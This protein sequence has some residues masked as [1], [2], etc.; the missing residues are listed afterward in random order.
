MRILLSCSNTSSPSFIFYKDSLKKLKNESKNIK[1]TAK[2]YE[3][4]LLEENFD[5]VLFMSGTKNSNFLKKKN[6]LYGLI[7]PRAGNYDNFDKY[8]FIIANGIEEK[9]FFSFTKLPT[10]IYPVYPLIKL[11]KK[12]FNKNKTII[13]YHGNREHLINMYPSIF[14]AINKIA[15]KHLIELLLIYDFKN[16]GKVSLFNQKEH[17]FKIYHKQYYDKCFE[18]Y[19]HDTDIGI[20]PQLIPSQ[21][22]KIKKNFSYHFSK[23][24][25]KKKYF[26]SL[27]F[28]ETTN[29]GRHFVFAQL[30][31]PTISDYT[32]SSSNFINNGIN[33]FLAHDTVDWYE[34]FEY[35]INNKK[36]S[37]KIGTKFY[38]DWKNQ[39]SHTILNKKFLKF[40][41][42]LNDK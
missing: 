19:L 34:R 13:S 39:Y 8:D 36:K 33:G 6:V 21:T 30:K 20:V 3:S 22:K 1:L 24:L 4:K 9:T 29:L 38:L 42:N 15:S 23:Q 37:K 31:I 32:L 35:L 5:V 14:N 16:K 10:L 17:N 7:D 41:K 12:K 18:K 2:K 27:N 28:K 11:K 26:F 25:F 40:I